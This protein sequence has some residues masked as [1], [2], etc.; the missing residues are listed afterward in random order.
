MR[1]RVIIKN[2]QSLPE[3]T[4]VSMLKDRIWT[5]PFLMLFIEMRLCKKPA[6]GKS[7]QHYVDEASAVFGEE[8]RLALG[9]MPEGFS[10]WSAPAAAAVP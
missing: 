10:A 5:I 1:V 9:S 7:R 6:S 4:D 2:A 3:V 8:S